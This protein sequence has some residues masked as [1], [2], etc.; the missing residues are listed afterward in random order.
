MQREPKPVFASCKIFPIFG[1][2]ECCVCHHTFGFEVGYSDHIMNIS[3]CKKCCGGSQEKADEIL[4]KIKAK[5]RPRF[6]PPPQVPIQK[7]SDENIRNKNNDYITRIE[8]NE[9]NT[10]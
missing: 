1:W 2:S 5:R 7:R 6:P 4:G 9:T 8:I 10:Q 3:V